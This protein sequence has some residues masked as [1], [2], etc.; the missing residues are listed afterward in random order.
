MSKNTPRRN[1][2]KRSNDRGSAS[3]RWLL[4][5]AAVSAFVGFIVYLDSVDPDSVSEQPEATAPDPTPE[6]ES[7]KEK[8]ERDFRF[9]DMLPESEVVTPD[10]EAYEPGPGMADR[11]LEY[12]LQVGS[13]RSHDDAERQRAEVGFQGLRAY[14]NEVSTN[15]GAIWYRVMV[16]PFDSR[17]DM[18][19]AVDRLVAINIQPLVRQRSTEKSDE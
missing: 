11:N 17:S 8:R 4:P 1:S 2:G 19:R 15:E 7:R 16:G 18:N 5:V 14:I 9:Y 6:S 10:I 12:I 3:F 13:F